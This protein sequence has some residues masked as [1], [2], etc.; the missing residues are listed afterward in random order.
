[1]HLGSSLCEFCLRRKILATHANDDLGRR[2]NIIDRANAL[3]RAPDIAPSF[4]QL[5]RSARLKVHDGLVA[6]RQMIGIKP[7]IDHALA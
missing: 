1:M 7:S 5:G 4:D 3:P 6:L 2:R